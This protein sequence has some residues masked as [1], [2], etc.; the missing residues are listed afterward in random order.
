MAS[1]ARCIAAVAELTA[2]AYGVPMRSANSRS[3][4]FVLGPVVSQPLRRVSTT[5][6]I[7]ACVICGRANGRNVA[8]GSPLLLLS[9]AMRRLLSMMLHHLD[10]CFQENH[11]I[12]LERLMF[13]VIEV[14]LQLF[15]FI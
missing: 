7:S 11:D 5:S 15:E 6:S 1:S 13:D 10:Y 14:V 12:E 3:N 2:R 4:R 9:R 8:R